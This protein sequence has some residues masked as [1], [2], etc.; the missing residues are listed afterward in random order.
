MI[1]NYFAEV[2]LFTVG[3][4]R[5]LYCKHGAYEVKDAAFLWERERGENEGRGGK[6][7][8]GRM[9]DGRG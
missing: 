7:R 4:Y 1:E 3:A 2:G 5:R 6:G 9:M 8:R